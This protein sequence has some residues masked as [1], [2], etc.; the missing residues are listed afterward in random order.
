M[1]TLMES[2]P[3]MDWRELATKDDLADLKEDLAD[4]EERLDARIDRRIAQHTYVILVGMAAMITPIYLALFS[5][6]A[7]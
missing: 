2:L 6:G 3:P 5:G 1:N 4:L 7:G